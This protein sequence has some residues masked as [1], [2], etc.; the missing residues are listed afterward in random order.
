MSEPEIQSTR[1]P[2]WPEWQGWPYLLI[3]LT[4][5]LRLIYIWNSRANPTFWAPAVDPAWYDEAALNILNGQWGPYPFFRAP[6]Y[7]ALLAGVYA[8]F[9]HDLTAARLLNVL[10]QAVTVWAILRIGKAYFAPAIGIIA[11]GLFA[12][13]GTAI[14]F[15]GE[16]LSTSA[17]MLAAALILWS[18]LRLARTRAMAALLLCGLSWGLA[19]IIRPNFLFAFPVGIAAVWLLG[20]DRL[21]QVFRHDIKRT[22][23]ASLIWLIGA[24]LPI[25]P[26]TAVNIIKGGEAVLI[27]TQGGVNFWIG[28]NPESTGIL[29]VLP[30]YGN[31]WTMEDAQLEADQEAGRSLSSGELSSFYYKKGWQFLASHPGA[32]L[33]FM[34]RK[35][36]LFFNQFEISNNKHISYFIEVSPWLPP[37]VWLNFGLLVP[38]GVLGIAIAWR[39]GTIRLILGL[40]LLYAVSVVLFFVTARFRMPIVPWLSLLAAGG[41]YWIVTQV[42]TRP[43]LRTWLPMLILIPGA[44][45]AHINLWDIHE[46]PVGWARYMEGNAYLKLNQL[47][48]ARDAFLDALQDGQAVARTQLNLGVIAY[49]QGRLQEARDWYRAA[50]LSD[51]T[52]VEALNNLG[53]VSEALGD[54]AGAIA[55]YE[56]ALAIRPTA[57]DPRHNL[58]AVHFKYGVAALK[59][60]QDSLAAYHLEKCLALQ[61]TAI[62]HYDLAIAYGRLGRNQDAL[63]QLDQSLRLDPHLESAARL[64]EQYYS[65]FPADSI[66]GAAPPDSD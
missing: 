3:G 9:G 56:H 4:V 51:T 17:E 35:S 31:T 41:L 52:N 60:G 48:S 30:G 16:I 47:D 43:A 22:A 32:S 66:S 55:Y 65:V 28:N 2:S 14:Y 8:I 45:L 27:A 20:K 42:R 53:T 33:R 15:A 19:A 50:H 12:L 26:I 58:A 44:L 46:A 63:H 39:Q 18:T 21:R 40:I 54:T 37:L 7:P 38:L 25:I 36:L 34:I 1:N 59:D 13:N 23:M 49:R 24:F 57:P 11:A 62:V 10:L 29:S 6:V 5:L 64:R 61:A